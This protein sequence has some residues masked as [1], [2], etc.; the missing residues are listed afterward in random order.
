MDLTASFD[1]YYSLWRRE[2]HSEGSS[3]LTVADTYELKQ[4]SGVVSLLNTWYPVREEDGMITIEG[5]ESVCKFRLPEGVRLEETL[6]MVRGE[7]LH[8]IGL[9]LEGTAGEM[10]LNFRF[11]PKHI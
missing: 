8:Q 9:H 3:V 10:V 1:E 7:T 6:R 11:E 5:R 2:L 4:G